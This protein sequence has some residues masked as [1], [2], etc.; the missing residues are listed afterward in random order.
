M[1]ARAAKPFENVSIEGITKLCR[2]L[3]KETNEFIAV[4]TQANAEAAKAAREDRAE[5]KAD[6]TSLRAELGEAR[7][8]L[9]VEQAKNLDRDVAFRR[10]ENEKA[11]ADATNKLLADALGI[12][13]KI[14]LGIVAH[15]SNPKA[16]P[17]LASGGAPTTEATG[18]PTAEVLIDELIR[19]LKPDTIAAAYGRLKPAILP[20]LAAQQFILASFN[21][22]VA[23][24][25]AGMLDRD[26]GGGVEATRRLSAIARAAGLST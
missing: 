3:S 15:L 13:G 11:A 7:R 19:D 14:G 23:S 26:L 12:G 2:D 9:Q 1:V 20:L 25:V 5:L 17:G 6:A 16:P 8:A 18:Q 4:Q 10:L 21:T 24:D 22:L